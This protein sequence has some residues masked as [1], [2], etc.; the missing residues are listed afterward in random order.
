VATTAAARNAKERGHAIIFTVI[1]NRCWGFIALS[2]A[3]RPNAKAVVD[4]IHA[5]GVRTVLLTGDTA[6]AA[7]NIA[8]K[9]G[10]AEVKAPCLPE[11]KLAAIRRYQENG[12]MICMVGDGINDA[13]ALKAAEVGVAMGGIGS[14]IAIEAADIV[15]VRD[16]IAELP[17]LLTLA[18]RVMGTIKINIAASLGLNFAAI[19]LA[20]IG[21]LNPIAGALAHNV[22][23]VAV[24]INS[25]LL[26]KWRNTH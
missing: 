13:A 19:I 21:V 6:L 10:I 7:N 17:S 9:V 14:D 16:D 24:I 11:D 2:D 4:A 3:P 20:I 8:A 5:R 25:S 18:R 1:D 26:L 23:S 15:L 12:E 22:G